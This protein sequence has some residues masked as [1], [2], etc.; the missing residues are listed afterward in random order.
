MPELLEKLRNASECTV[1]GTSKVNCHRLR[2][3]A[4]GVLRGKRI[5]RL[6]AE[7]VY[8]DEAQVGNVFSPKTRGLPWCGSAS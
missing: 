3:I 2:H 8:Q 5:L 7:L 1:S 6:P 4:A